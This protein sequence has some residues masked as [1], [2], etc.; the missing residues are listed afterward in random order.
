MALL[1]ILSL[2]RFFYDSRPSR[3]FYTSNQVR[4]RPMYLLLSLSAI[5]LYIKSLCHLDNTLTDKADIRTKE[6][7]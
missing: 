7:S 2:I 1:F 3:D 5:D 4:S 6:K